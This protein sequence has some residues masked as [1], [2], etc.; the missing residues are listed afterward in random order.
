MKLDNENFKNT[1][2]VGLDIGTSKVVF[3]VCEV[4]PNDQLSLIAIGEEPNKGMKNGMVSNIEAV[5]RSI[6]AAKQSLKSMS[7]R[8]IDEVFASVSGS[9]VYSQNLDGSIQIQTGEVTSEDIEQVVSDVANTVSVSG[10]ERLLHT[11]S[12]HYSVDKLGL[13]RDPIGMSGSNLSVN[14]HAVKGEAGPIENLRRCI[15][16]C[17]LGVEEMLLS[18]IA[19]GQTV[20]S[21]DEKD[22]GTVLIDIGDGTTDIAVFSEGA[23]VH[24]S[25]IDIAGANLTHDIAVQLHT[26]REEAD[27]I[28]KRFGCALESVVD[29]NE[30]FGVCEIGHARK[31]QVERKWLARIIETQMRDL[32]LRIYK[33]LEE[34][35]FGLNLINSSVVLIGGTSKLN[36]ISELAEQVFKRPVRLGSSAYAGVLSELVQHPGYATSMGLCEYGHLVRQHRAIKAIEYDRSVSVDIKSRTKDALKRIFSVQHSK[37]VGT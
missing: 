2:L 34:D 4:L 30:Y 26:T 13:I 37:A 9:H 29:S 5:S 36:H 24:S 35:E 21:D 32:L 6:E 1:P 16:R 28:K 11:I 19:A 15:S 12:Q 25:T 8:E 22:L 27:Q 7:M 18:H 14:V 33:K 20:L 10:D 23:I 17:G 31:H 3:V